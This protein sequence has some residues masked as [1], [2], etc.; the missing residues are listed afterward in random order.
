VVSNGLM[1]HS[2]LNLG[3][4][5]RKFEKRGG[6]KSVPRAPVIPNRRIINLFGEFLVCYFEYYAK[7]VSNG[8]MS[9]SSLNLGHRAFVDNTRLSTL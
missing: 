4:P 8:L 1:S 6:G 5:N 7:V 3:H 9:H 2:S